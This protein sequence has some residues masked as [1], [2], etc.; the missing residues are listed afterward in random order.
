MPCI[1]LVR[2]AEILT[3]MHTTDQQKRKRVRMANN[4]HFE[5][6]DKKAQKGMM[7]G[8]VEDWWGNRAPF[9]GIAHGT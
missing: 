8:M 9:C 1:S 3:C 7:V 5:A 6:N 2:Q 4:E